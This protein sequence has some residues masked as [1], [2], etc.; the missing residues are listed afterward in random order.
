MPPGLLDSQFAALEAP[1]AGEPAVR[2]DVDA[3]PEAI[4]EAVLQRLRGATN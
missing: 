1:G 4:V 3:P 2:V